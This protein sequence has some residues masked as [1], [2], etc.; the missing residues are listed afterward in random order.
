MGVTGKDIA[1]D[2]KNKRRENIEKKKELISGENEDKMSKG[3][4]VLM[5]NTGIIRGDDES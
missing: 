1:I 2:K 5:K 3:R 4:E